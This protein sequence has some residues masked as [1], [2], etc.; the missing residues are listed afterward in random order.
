MLFITLIEITRAEFSFPFLIRDTGEFLIEIKL[1]KLR[2]VSSSVVHLDNP[3][4]RRAEI[5][6]C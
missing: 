4:K 6:G 5:A 2:R 1:D 3:H